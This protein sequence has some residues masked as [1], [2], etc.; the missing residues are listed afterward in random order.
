MKAIVIVTLSVVAF[1]AIALFV[2]K[3]FKMVPSSA[4]PADLDWYV[5]KAQQWELQARILRISQVVLAITA[6]TASVLSAS[7]WKPPLLPNGFLAV[8]AAVSIALLT[9]LDLTNQANKVRNAERHLTFSIIEFRQTSG[10]SLDKLLE[11]YQKA[12]SIIGDYSPQ[13]G[14]Q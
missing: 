2:W 8:L 6:I 13:V 14:G 4:Q 5:L 10:A 12:E 11:S 1:A 7:Q 3:Y 9:G